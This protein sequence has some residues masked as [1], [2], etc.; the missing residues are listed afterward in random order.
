MRNPIKAVWT[1]LSL[2]NALSGLAR[3]VFAATIA[4]IAT[5]A[6]AVTII[7]LA[8]TFSVEGKMAGIMAACL[9]APHVLGP[10]YGRILDE[11][12]D[13][14]H[15]IAAAT[16]VYPGFFKLAMWGL[17]NNHIWLVISSLLV[18]GACSSFMMGGLSTQLVKLVGNDLTTRRRAQSWDTLTYGIGLTIGPLMIAVLTSVVSIQQ[19]ASILMNL[20]I[21]AGMLILCLPL[22]SLREA[23]DQK[24]MPNFKQVA[25]ILYQS[26]R[27][28]RTICMTAGASFSIAALPVLAVYL[29]ELWQNSQE[30]GAYLVTLYGVGTLCGALLLMLKPMREEALILLRNIGIVLLITLILIAL[31][32]SFQ[33]GLVTYWLCGVV[34]AIFFAATLAARTE[35]APEQG[36]AQVYLWVAAAKISA[37]SIGAIVAGYL[38]DASVHLPLIVA[39]VILSLIIFLC[40]GR[41]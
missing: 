2:D 10:V 32:P 9:T 3:Y 31:S 14:R 39:S 33:I 16:F 41:R 37:G 8:R 15:I 5:G 23:Q 21:V 6:S 17:E 20:P 28:K 18:C 12:R 27:L 4:R 29:G 24:P 22:L 13:P 35:Y 34:N 7:L 38:V 11:A 40:F 1:R 25:N 30:R 26:G 36:A 19:S